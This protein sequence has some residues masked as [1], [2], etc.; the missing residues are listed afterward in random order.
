MQTLLTIGTQQ[1]V[2]DHPQDIELSFDGHT[3][4]STLKSHRSLE[5]Q[6]NEALGSEGIQWGDAIAW[7]TDKAGVKPCAPCKSRIHILNHVKQLGL[8][9]TLRQLKETFHGSR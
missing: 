8:K 9:E 4:R 7:A 1:I 2:I 6:L 5:A 3:L